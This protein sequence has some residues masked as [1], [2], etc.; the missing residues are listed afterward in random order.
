MLLQLLIIAA[1]LLPLATLAIVVFVSWGAGWG[2]TPAERAMR[3]PG[4]E[5]FTDRASA[6]VAMTRAVSITAPPETVWPWLAQLGRGAGWYSF[7]RLD[8]GGL[9]SARHIVSWIPT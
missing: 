8:N 5:F 4:D 1:I 7:D 6:F 2:A 3:M 9:V